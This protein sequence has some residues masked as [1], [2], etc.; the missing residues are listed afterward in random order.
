MRNRTFIF[1]LI[2]IIIVQS[3][4]LGSIGITTVNAE[5]IN[6]PNFSISRTMDKEIYNQWDTAKITYNITPTGQYTTIPQST[7]D[8]IIAM[9]IYSGMSASKLSSA[10]SAAI[11]FINKIKAANANNKVG[12]VSFGYKVNKSIALTDNLDSISSYIAGIN[13]SNM[14]EGSNFQDAIEKSQ[15]MLEGSNNLNK[16]IVFISDGFPNYYTS[17]K[18][19]GKFKKGDVKYEDGVYYYSDVTKV[20]QEAYINTTKACKSL[21]NKG[22]VLYSVGIGTGTDVDMSF[23]RSM[24]QET[25]GSAYQTALPDSVVQVMTKTPPSTNTVKL[26][27]LVIKDKLPAGIT[28]TNNSLVVPDS[29][30]NISIEIPDIIY[31]SDGTIPTSFSY[32]LEVSLNNA[33]S[34]TLNN[35]RI[36]YLDIYSTAKSKPINDLSFTVNPN[37]S[38]PP[39]LTINKQISKVELIEGETASLNYTITPIGSFNKNADRKPLDIVITIDRSYGMNEANKLVNTK[40]EAENLVNIFKTANQG[41]RIS[42]VTFNRYSKIVVPLTSDYD[43]LINSIRQIQVDDGYG[44]DSGTNM[45]I[46]LKAAEN[47][48]VDSTNQ[49]HIVYFSD[50]VPSCYTD[51]IDTNSYV[52]YYKYIYDYGYKLESEKYN[53]WYFNPSNVNFYGT[54]MFDYNLEYG[55]YSYQQ[56]TGNRGYIDARVQANSIK[57]KGIVLNTVCVTG[58]TDTNLSFMQELASLGGGTAYTIATSVELNNK[59]EAMAKESSTQILSNIKITEALP[60]DIDIIANPDISINGRIMT[61][62]VPD[63]EF[64]KDKGTPAPITVSVDLKF[65]K[66][67]VYKLSNI[68]RL[69]YTNYD[70]NAGIP[71]NTQVLTVTVVKAAPIYADINTYDGSKQISVIRK[72]KFDAKISFNVVNNGILNLKL[73]TVS[74][75]EELFSSLSSSAEIRDNIGNIYKLTKTPEGIFITTD[76]KLAEGDY[77]ITI[78][79]SIGNILEKSYFLQLDLGLGADN[80]SIRID[81]VAMPILL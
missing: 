40:Q 67:G 81:V 11:D 49:R 10:K 39:G 44:Y 27:G 63:I 46:G 38:L 8:I 42:L 30:G 14:V 31:N 9:N 73:C 80:P 68:S 19:L 24:S 22:I 37:E 41:D 75:S 65:T 3:I 28:V 23:L 47:A 61:I 15:V 52:Y 7:S 5:V 25:G 77:E 48:L 26:S 2:A 64:E 1:I 76:Y 58:G 53:K 54:S 51:A 29:L 74:G 18:W 34:Y 13:S 4:N 56:G 66:E 70:G 33:G 62:N 12:F 45:E 55:E 71:I 16:N 43:T 78:K 17:Y 20:T 36:D 32:V 59:F 72:G 50:G 21:A 35:S 6:P 57:S 79:L 69:D 60:L